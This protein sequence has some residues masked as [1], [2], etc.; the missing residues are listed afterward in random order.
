MHFDFFSPCSQAIDLTAARDHRNGRGL[1]QNLG[2]TFKCSRSVDIVTIE[3]R[4]Q[5]ALGPIDSFVPGIIDPLVR[6]GEYLQVRISPQKIQGSIRRSAIDNPVLKIRV[7]LSEN[8]FNRRPD[9][10]LPI[11]RCS[12]D[13][14]LHANEKAER[15][16]LSR[17]TIRAIS[18]S[19][20]FLPSPLR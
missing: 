17:D 8:A 5:L 6:L 4:N 12:D 15:L 18:A 3:D 2:A 9:E 7:V 16:R 11:E 20:D 13:R 1:F 19:N 10:V 14:N